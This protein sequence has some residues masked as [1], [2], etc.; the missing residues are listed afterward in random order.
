MGINLNGTTAQGTPETTGI[1]LE[2]EKPPEMQDVT[3]YKQKLRTLPEVQ[4]MTNE[5]NIQEPNS[6]LEFGQKPAESLSRMADQ[7]LST[8]KGVKAEEASEMMNQLT[9]IMDKF[10]IKEIEDLEKQ[11]FFEKLFNKAKDKVEKLFKKYDDMGHEVDKIAM[12][13]RKY[14]N[15]LRT[16]NSD[17]DKMLQAC[18]SYYHELEKYIVAGEIGMEEIAEYKKSIEND[19]ERPEADK[20]M[21]CDKLDTISG[22]LSQRIY[23]LQVAENVAMQQVP[24]LNMMMNSNFNL[25]RKIN[26]SFII[27]LPIFKQCLIQAINLKRAEIQARSINQLDEK[28]NELLLRN[29]QNTATQ[30]VKLAEMAGGSSIKMETLKE[31]YATIQRGL[32]E[33]NAMNEQQAREREANSKDL[34]VMKADMKAKNFAV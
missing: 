31:T 34:E 8:M 6:V 9:K 26:S 33:T 24:M 7:I 17:L 27:T 15:D 23:D 25:Q 22:M 21:A 19:T 3:A 10:D 13:L 2:M 28:T 32:E 29:A 14:E 4:T 1:N 20:R 16:A 30:S 12:I 5:I 18:I 11:G